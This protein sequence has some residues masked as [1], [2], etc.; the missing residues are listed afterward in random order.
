MV[1]TRT[2]RTVRRFGELNAALTAVQSSLSRATLHARIHHFV[3]CASCSRTEMSRDD[4]VEIRQPLVD[5]RRNT[6]TQMRSPLVIPDHTAFALAVLLLASI[7]LPAVCSS[8]E[9]GQWWSDP[10]DRLRK[11]R[12]HVGTHKVHT[13]LNNVIADLNRNQFPKLRQIFKTVGTSSTNLKFFITTLKSLQT[14]NTSFFCMLQAMPH[15]LPIANYSW[16]NFANFKK[17]MKK[18]KNKDYVSNHIPYSH[19]QFFISNN[20]LN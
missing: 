20:N 7:F 16:L 11:A 17:A 8:Q 12:H 13:Q 19:L 3:P 6:G 14:I 18:H 10:C 1:R 9:P 2:K 5:L 4:S 15:S